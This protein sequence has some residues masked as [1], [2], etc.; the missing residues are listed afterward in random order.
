MNTTPI[1]QLRTKVIKKAFKFQL[2]TQI[3]WK[4]I[5]TSFKNHKY[6]KTLRPNCMLINSCQCLWRITQKCCCNII[7]KVD[8]EQ[9]ESPG[10]KK[11]LQPSEWEHMTK[12]RQIHRMGEPQTLIIKKLRRPRRPLSEMISKGAYTTRY[13]TRRRRIWLICLLVW[14]SRCRSINVT[15][16][17]TP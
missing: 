12:T 1:I 17:Y 2:N 11:R 3:Q 5:I 7:M 16:S 10:N 15:N 8:L 14:N 9:I 13:W 4:I 6:L